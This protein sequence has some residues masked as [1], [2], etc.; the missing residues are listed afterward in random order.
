MKK[1]LLYHASIAVCGATLAVLGASE[2]NSG[3]ITVVSVLFAVSGTGM[4]LGAVYEAFR[5][6]DPAENLPDD[7]LVWFTIAMGV[8]A[9]VA[10]LWSA[11]T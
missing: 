11:L 10:G 8:I 7:R 6:D 5:S 3:N 2:V 1:A 4:L 9:T